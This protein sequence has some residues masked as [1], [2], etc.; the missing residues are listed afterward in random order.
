MRI[1]IVLLTLTLASIAIACGGNQHATGQSSQNGFNPPAPTPGTPNPA[2]VIQSLDDAI[3]KA[4]NEFIG[5]TGDPAIAAH[6][7]SLAY[8]QT[9]AGQAYALVSSG[10]SIDPALA[11]KTAWL[12][13]EQ[14]TF[15]HIGFK[16]ATPG[17]VKHTLWV[18]A[19]QGYTSLI[20]NG[21][22]ANDGPTVDLSSLGTARRT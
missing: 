16:N 3:V 18:L 8:I 10:A 21:S 11:N 7:Q 2:Y 1:I 9:T 6:V 19:I 22:A 15:Q 5:Q 14:G 17:P 20:S 12:F 4:T 13:V